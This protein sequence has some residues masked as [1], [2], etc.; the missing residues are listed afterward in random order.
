MEQGAATDLQALIR[1]LSFSWHISLAEAHKVVWCV[2]GH[3]TRENIDRQT[4]QLS[5]SQFDDI[6]Y[7]S[8]ITEQN[9]MQLARQ[10]AL[11]AI[12]LAS[13]FRELSVSILG[14]SNETGVSRGPWRRSL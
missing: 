2:S 14:G 4:A 12:A 6:G 9:N 1:G 13:D 7:E 8:T 3:L 10:A 11:L 5:L